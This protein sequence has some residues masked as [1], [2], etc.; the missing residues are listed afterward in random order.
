MIADRAVPICPTSD[1]ADF[2]I[3]TYAINGLLLMNY[4]VMWYIEY[5][6]KFYILAHNT[7]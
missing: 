4:F 2:H 5:S 7:M 3:F 6:M 1:Y